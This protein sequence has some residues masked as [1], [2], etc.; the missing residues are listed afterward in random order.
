MFQR[1]VTLGEVRGIPVR[2]DPSW[3]II[4]ALVAFSFWRQFTFYGHPDVAAVAMSLLTAILFFVSVLVHEL[5]HALEAQQRG[6]EVGGITLF[7]FG[8]VTEMHLEAKRPRDE[9]ALAAVGPY[10]SLVLAAVFGLVA[11]YAN[12]YGPAAAAPIGDIA[13][14]LGWINVGLA[15][16]NLL[17]GAPLDGGRVLRSGLWA[18]TRDRVRAMRL[19]GRAGQLLAIALMTYGAL[20]LLTVPGGAFTGIWFA[21][22]AW[23]MLQAAST[24]VAQA[25]VR[26]LVA[27]RTIGAI[28]HASAPRVPAS[29]SVA[30]A[31]ARL[32]AE[33]HLAFPVEDDGEVVGA[34][35]AED[36]AAMDPQDRTFRLV[37]EIM[38]P[39]DDVPIVSEDTP[40]LD[41][42]ST[43]APDDTGLLLVRRDDGDVLLTRLDIARA[44]ARLRSL[45]RK[46]RP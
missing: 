7:L 3:L 33:G 40:I 22:I 11:A 34:L 15:V 39:L 10:A 28:V 8:G 16:F 45:E 25:D 9:F 35:L 27:D 1:A 20:L 30:V 14:L 23:F 4:A 13:G 38:R 21:L 37:S 17:P 43:P 24:E 18:L 31:E 44:L 32:A 36:V 2:V 42:L 12:T 19:A 46:R 5:A 41:V 29:H 26:G 6:V